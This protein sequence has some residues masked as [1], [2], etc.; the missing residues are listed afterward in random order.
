MI[1]RQQLL[2]WCKPLLVST[3][4]LLAA[5]NPIAIISTNPS[6]AT[7]GESVTFDGSGTVISNTPTDTV[8]SSYEWDF[9]DGSSAK[10]EAVSHTYTAAGTYTVTLTVTDSAGREGST[11]EEI[12]VEP[13]SQTTTTT[14]MSFTPRLT[15]SRTA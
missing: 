3:V 13:A 12:T 4:V 10:G 8:A 15:S 14:S 5:C 9:G 2:S 7:V 6:P 1:S 11:T